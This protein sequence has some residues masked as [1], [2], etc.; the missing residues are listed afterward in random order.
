MA[1][2]LVTWR[3]FLEAASPREAALAALAAQRDPESSA[4]CFDVRDETGRRSTIVCPA[5]NDSPGPAV[6]E[7]VLLFRR[8][9]RLVKTSRA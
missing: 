3:I 5:A 9:L 6:G 7:T 1:E 4:T 2:Y 8:H